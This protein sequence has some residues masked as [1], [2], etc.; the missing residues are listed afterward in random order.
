MDFVVQENDTDGCVK[1]IVFTDNM[2][3]DFGLLRYQEAIDLADTLSST[4][5]EIYDLT[6]ASGAGL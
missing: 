5:D 3:M 1:V 4:A 6:M 2:T